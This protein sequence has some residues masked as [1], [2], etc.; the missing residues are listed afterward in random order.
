MDDKKFQ[1]ERKIIKS[2]SADDAKMASTGLIRKQN[3]KHLGKVAPGNINTEKTCECS[4]LTRINS[5]FLFIGPMIA[6]LPKL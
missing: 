4:W 6:F 5:C 2:C 3:V 1:E